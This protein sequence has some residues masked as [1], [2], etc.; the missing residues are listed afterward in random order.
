MNIII[1][2]LLAAGIIISSPDSR[3]SVEL[4]STS[5]S[6]I[7]YSVSYDGESVILPSKLGL[8]TNNADYR[9]LEYIEHR[10]ELTTVDYELD[11]IKKNVIRKEATRAIVSFRNPEGRRIDI[12]WHIS[13]NDIARRKLL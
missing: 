5:A 12:E 2:A 7:C 3:L 4:N 13:D 6:N 9:Q 8:L 1:S 10:E 11:R